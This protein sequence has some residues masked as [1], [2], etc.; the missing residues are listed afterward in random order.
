MEMTNKALAKELVTL[1]LAKSIV[2]GDAI[3]ADAALKAGADPEAF[4]SD[5][6]P[7]LREL[8]GK[9]T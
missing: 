3:G 5:G 4:W 2:E 8:T 1:T 9:W 7:R 6:R